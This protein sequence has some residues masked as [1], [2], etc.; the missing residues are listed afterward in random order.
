MYCFAKIKD[1]AYNNLRGGAN[2]TGLKQ[3]R[4]Q[5]GAQ[6]GKTLPQR[7]VAEAVGITP[8]FYN[9]VECGREDASLS[10]WKRL[11]VYF[12]KTIDELIREVPE[13]S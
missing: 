9:A 1:Y 8:Q 10:L 2:M 4:L 3:A 6:R 5:K 11:S 13:Q 12:G 7:E